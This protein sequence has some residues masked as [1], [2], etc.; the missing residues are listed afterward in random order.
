MTSNV[1]SASVL[2]PPDENYRPSVRATMLM[3]RAREKKLI[4]E[5]RVAERREEGEEGGTTCGGEERGR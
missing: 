1:E 3:R 5:Q 4:F 2:F